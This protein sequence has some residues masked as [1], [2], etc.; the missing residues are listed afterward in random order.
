MATLINLQVKKIK[1]LKRDNKVFNVSGGLQSTFSLRELSNWC[2]KNIS[3]K[4]IKSSRKNR[5]FD[6]KWVV[7]DNLKAK[8]KFN[9][10]IKYYKNHIF[11][12]ILNAND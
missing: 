8:K 6:V 1:K 3:L 4:Q 7:L 10:K 2:C 9:W 12:E 5:I 11:K